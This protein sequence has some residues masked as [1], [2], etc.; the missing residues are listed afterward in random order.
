MGCIAA[1]PQARETDVCAPAAHSA[2]FEKMTAGELADGEAVLRLKI[3]MSAGNI[4]LRDPAIYRL[5]RD[6]DH[7]Q[8]GTKWKVY[9]MYDYAHALTDAHEGITHS[10]W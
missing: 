9:P 6:A 5:K 2:L 10:L 8:T 3:D 1:Q 4:N 7:P